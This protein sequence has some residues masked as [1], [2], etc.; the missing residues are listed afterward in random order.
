MNWSIPSKSV[1][2]GACWNRHRNRGV[3]RDR[4][5]LALCQLEIESR[6]LGRRIQ[7]VLCRIPPMDRLHVAWNLIAREESKGWRAARDKGKSRGSTGKLKIEVVPRQ[8]K[9]CNSPRILFIL[10]ETEVVS[11]TFE[12]IVDDKTRLT[13]DFWIEYNEYERIH[14]GC[15]N[16]D[17]TVVD[18]LTVHEKISR[19]YGINLFRSRLCSRE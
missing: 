6:P 2:V 10:R 7:G 1:T 18:G 11:G 17:G 5:S 3:R 15:L 4:S 9:F 8:S 14:T 13:Q 12:N 16:I 19:I